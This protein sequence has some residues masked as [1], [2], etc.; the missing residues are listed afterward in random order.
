[1]TSKDITIVITTYKSEEKIESCLNS[2]DS[3]IRV[4]IIEN[5][6]NKKFKND[7]ENKFSN[8]E[9]VL[10]NDNLG[11]GRANNIGL[12]KVTTRYS[13]ILNPDTIL[14]KETIDN[15]FVF[16]KKNINF[17][18]L[19][20]LQ[21][22]NSLESETH[23]HHQSD[24]FEADSVKGFAMFL[25]MSKFSQIGF[26]DEKFFLYLEEVDLCK[27]VKKINEKIYINKNIKIFHFGGKS[28]K[29]S[30]FYQIELTRNWHWMWSFFYFNKKHQNYFYAL[31]LIFPKFFSALFKS[32]FYKFFFKSKKSEIY[33][34]RLSGL[35]NS[36]IGKPSWY[37]PTLD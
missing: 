37:R 12:K 8:V 9:C 14:E 11:Y 20:P 1:M 27:R 32:F 4:I 17:A 13:L 35:F 3:K 16:L 30:L 5:S 22:E 24:Y 25:N 21:N 33:S 6:S 26:F 31:V 15:F 29:E 36:I 2:I 23:N 19:G 28:V 7:I 34:K 10:T 18:I